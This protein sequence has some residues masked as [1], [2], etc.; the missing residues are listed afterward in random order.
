MKLHSLVMFPLLAAMTGLAAADPCVKVRKGESDACM[1]FSSSQKRNAAKHG[2]QLGAP[3]KAT[4]QALARQGWV[5]DRQWLSDGDSRQSNDREMVCGSGADAVC[6]TAFR[7]K[8]AVLLLTLSSTNEGM[9]L[10][11]TEVIA[12]RSPAPGLARTL[13]TPSFIIRITVN[14]EEGNV[15]CDDVTYVGTSR[16]TSDSISLRGKTRHSTCTDGASPCTF[17]GYEFRNGRTLYR[18]LDDGRLSVI[19]QNKVLLE[20]KGRWE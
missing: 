20:E 19:Q 16:K 18:V 8:G 17:Q 5:L 6:Q 3:F 14:C 9:P 11:D 4:K 7:R 15:T 1:K 2:L 10:V 12:P 13:T